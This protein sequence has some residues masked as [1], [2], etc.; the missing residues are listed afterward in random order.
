M[1]QYI[2]HI[3]SFLRKSWSLLAIL[4]VLIITI[5]RSAENAPWRKD[6]L[7]RSDAMHYYGYLPAVLLHQDM[8]FTYLDTLTAESAK[9][10][11]FMFDTTGDGERHFK[12]WV[13]E[14]VMLSPFFLLGHA[15]ASANGEMLHGYGPSYYW[16][17]ALGAWVYL[18]LGL[19]CIRSVLRK[20]EF[21]E[22]VVAATLLLLGLG[23]NLLYYS[24]IEMAMSHVYSFFLFALFFWLLLRGQE[25][26]RPLRSIVL[27]IVVGLIVLTRPTNLLIVLVALLWGVH[28]LTTL[29]A[30]LRSLRA[31]YR[32]IALSAL[33]AGVVLSIQP[34]LWHWGTGHWF[35]HSYGD[36]TFFWTDPQ[37]GKVLFSYRKGW[38]IYTPLMVLCLPGLILGWRKFGSYQ[39][40]LG[41][42]LLLN[43]YVVSSWWCWWYGGSLGHRAFIE[44]YALLSVPLAISLSYLLRK[45]WTVLT[46]A[47]LGG[48]ITFNIRIHDRYEAGILHPDS[49]SREAFWI[50]L[51]TEKVE[52]SYWSLMDVPSYWNRFIGSTEEEPFRRALSYEPQA[53]ISSEEFP[54]LMLDTAAAD[55]FPGKERTTLI[56]DAHV[57]CSDSLEKENDL[58]VV[59][60]IHNFEKERDYL[61][62][63][64]PLSTFAR[65]V[66]GRIH[67]YHREDISFLSDGAARVK[68]YLWNPK[69]RRVK[70]NEYGVG[71]EIY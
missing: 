53:R 15:M 36:E 2:E 31:N 40:P 8:R 7:I 10:M 12:M 33:S 18:G 57:E 50:M 55:Y 5:Q 9:G 30:R 13:G 26:L 39:F 63:T 14:A 42:F 23:T 43:I 60:S 48:A 28:S 51:G 67:L 59:L 49:M 20:L 41:V 66:Q 56:L 61:Y 65:D 70:V 19:L 46:C 6:T 11:H 34:I 17:L 35:I 21:E 32:L 16:A 62:R 64:L 69:L 54:C 68:V 52:S 71:Q 3:A 27:G 38:F 58:M 47:V 1:A 25:K 44:S 37:F 4:T 29:Q 24:S 22:H 45:W